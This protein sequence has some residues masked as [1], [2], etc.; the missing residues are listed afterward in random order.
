MGGLIMDRK[1]LPR[2]FLVIILITF[3]GLVGHA[4]AYRGGW[5]ESGGRGPGYYHNWYGNPGADI[6]EKDL[7]KLNAEREAFFKETKELRQNIHSKELELGNE[8]AK[9]E[10]DAE[11]AANL[12]REL[13]ELYAQ[14]DQKRLEHRIKIR[15][16][17]PYAERE[18]GYGNRY[19]GR[20]PGAG[21]CW[22]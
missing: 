4:L 17:I 7:D 1:Y 9:N 2:I 19:Y 11:K 13:S 8:L 21:Y 16:I 14:F 20:G 5:G 6:S 22:R 12:Q 3:L 10:L 15:D 18:M